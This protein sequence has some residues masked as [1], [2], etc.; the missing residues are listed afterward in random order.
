M[1]NRLR[2]LG[3]I[4]WMAAGIFAAG[5]CAAAQSPAQAERRVYEGV[6]SW[7]QKTIGTLILIEGDA[8]SARGWIRLNTYLPIDSGSL[9]K[10][11][12]E[13]RSGQNAYRIDEVR[14]RITYSGPEGEGTRLVQR[15]TAW[16]GHIHELL[17]ATER[18]PAVAKIEVAGRSREL[19]YG[20]P[21]LWKQQGPPFE[22]FPRLDE[23]LSTEITVW[24]GEA[25]L[26]SGRL[27]VVE[28]P[29]G[30]N[31]PLKAPKKD[32]KKDTDDK[33]KK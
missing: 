18:K 32:D 31:I 23:L 29:A 28:E 22:R 6:A 26:R 15:L 33:P 2:C 16:T 5:V 13:F 3:G 10:N 27:V 19:I 9:S 11:G 24:V 30:M 4:A 20:S 8:T 25:G 7:R 17:E 1:A 21:S 12:A 14:E